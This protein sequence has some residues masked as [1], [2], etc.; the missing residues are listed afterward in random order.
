M[1]REKKAGNLLTGQSISLE[2]V[3]CIVVYTVSPME[4]PNL[5]NGPLQG[6]NII[7]SHLVSNTFKAKMRCHRHTHPVIKEILS[8]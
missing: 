6:N 1:G 2:H 8:S 7:E 5:F 4:A 3:E